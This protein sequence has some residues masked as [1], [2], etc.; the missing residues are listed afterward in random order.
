VFGLAWGVTSSA[1][2]VLHAINGSPGAT[3]ELLT[4]TAANVLAT[5]LRFALLKAWVFRR[6]TMARGSNNRQVARVPLEDAA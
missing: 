3:A 1:L 5:V 4:L 2:V 6:R